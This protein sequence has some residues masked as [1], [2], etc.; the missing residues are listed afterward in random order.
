MRIPWPPQWVWR[1]SGGEPNVHFRVSG[2]CPKLPTPVQT[3]KS[4]EKSGVFVIFCRCVHKPGS[5]FTGFSVYFGLTLRPF[6]EYVF[7]P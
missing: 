5:V 2:V 7:F 4:G 6:G 1:S 3:E